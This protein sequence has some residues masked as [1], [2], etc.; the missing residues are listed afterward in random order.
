MDQSDIR[1]R[2]VSHEFPFISQVHT[3]HRHV[4]VDHSQSPV[5]SLTL[6]HSSKVGVTVTQSPSH[7]QSFTGVLYQV[8]SRFCKRRGT[9]FKSLLIWQAVVVCWV[10]VEVLSP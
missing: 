2:D 4:E 10:A 7:V 6:Q 1:G 3:W 8:G 5:L 9:L